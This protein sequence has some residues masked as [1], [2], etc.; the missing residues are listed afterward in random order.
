MFQ[1]K[2]KKPYHAIKKTEKNLRAQ[3]QNTENIYEKTLIK[4][5]IK[6]IKEQITDKM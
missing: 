5:R 4:E 1:V 2:S 3:Y 6:L